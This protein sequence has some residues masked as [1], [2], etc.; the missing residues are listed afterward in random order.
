M[1]SN[2]D[3][4]PVSLNEMLAIEIHFGKGRKDIV[5]VHFDDKP[6]DLATKFVAKH[7]LKISAIPI[8]TSHIANTIAEF[9]ENNAEIRPQSPDQVNDGLAEFTTDFI[10]RNTLSNDMQSAQPPVELPSSPPID[11]QI[12]EISNDKISLI[13]S[14]SRPN[15]RPSSANGRIDSRLDKR[16]D[17]TIGSAI[18]SDNE[19]TFKPKL[20]KYENHRHRPNDLSVYDMLY[21]NA[22]LNKMKLEEKRKI[23]NENELKNYTFQ[24]KL[25]KLPANVIP[26][27]RESTVRESLDKIDSNAE[28]NDTDKRKIYS[29]ISKSMSPTRSRVR[30]SSAS[31]AIPSVITSYSSTNASRLRSNSFSRYSYSHSEVKSTNKPP[32]LPYEHNIKPTSE[33]N[34]K[35]VDDLTINRT[36]RPLHRWGV[37]I[38]N[39]ADLNQQN[40]STLTV[41][42][43]IENILKRVTS[44]SKNVVTS[45]VTISSSTKSTTVPTQR[46]SIGSISTAES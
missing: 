38:V 28:D 31:K 20:F 19:F 6:D 42:Q 34:D 21:S 30:P 11:K 43:A 4:N 33:T 1:E 37:D 18:A 46:L 27:R 25:F 32:L 10:D 15:S 13:R 40:L 24:P 39:V 29:P 45:G 22:K 16:I 17:R 7:K 8:I 36:N 2:N 41:N 44:S 12:N 23:L 3:D 35:V 5:N 9:L 14:T 26:K